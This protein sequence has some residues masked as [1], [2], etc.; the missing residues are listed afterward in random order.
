M[1]SPP[2]KLAVL[3]RLLAKLKAKGHRVVMFTQ[4][5]LMLDILQDYCERKGHV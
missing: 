5:T 2:G 1:Q 4:F 3:D